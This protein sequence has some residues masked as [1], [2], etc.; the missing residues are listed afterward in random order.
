MTTNEIDM[1]VDYL[2][3]LELL[4]ERAKKNKNDDGASPDDRRR[5]AIVYTD[6]EKVKAYI[7]TYLSI[8]EAE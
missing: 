5:W 2:G 4:L 3:T 1:P 6:L 7:L 8:A